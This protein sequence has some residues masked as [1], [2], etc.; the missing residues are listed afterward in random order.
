MEYAVSG[1][2][3]MVIGLISDTHLLSGSTLPTQIDT[4]F[5]DVDLILHAGDIYNS[6]VL[7]R[8]EQIAPALATEGDEDLFQEID[9]RVQ[10]EH[11]LLF[12]GLNLWLIHKIPLHF[13]QLLASGAD[14]ELLDSIGRVCATTP[15]VIVFGDTHRA[16]VQNVKGI[17]FVNPGS[18]TVPNHLSG[19][20]T[21]ALLT[22]S[23]GRT[24][25]R[26]VQLR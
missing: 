10:H 26:I 21:V 17:L 1:K 22:I 12:G 4:I 13:L 7:D 11:I 14:A 3:E 24:E 23:S 18:P 16:L 19:P 5:R 25:T 15:D 6:S 2:S 8:L 20:G 9:D